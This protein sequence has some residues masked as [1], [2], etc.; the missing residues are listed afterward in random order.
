[1]NYENLAKTLLELVGGE[2]NIIS[3]THCATRLRFVLKDNKRPDE[4]KIKQQKGVVSTVRGGG[5]FQVVIGSDVGR[6]Y[7]ELLKLG[8]FNGS[9]TPA[10][11][12]RS[13]ATN[14]LDFIAGSFT[15]ILPA[16]TGA[17]MIKAVLALLMA[18]NLISDQSVTYKVLEIMSDGAFYFLPIFLAYTSAAK[19]KANPFLAMGIAGALL[20]PNFAGLFGEGVLN[21]YFLGFLPIR[22][23]SYG[24]SVIPILLS[25]FFMSYVERFADRISPKSVKFFLKPLIVVLVVT[26]IT[27]SVFGPIGSIIGDYLVQGV[28]A[29][30]NKVGFIAVALMGAFS[31][32]MV[33]FGMHYAFFPVMFTS[34][35]NFGYEALMIPGMLAA[36]VA[37][38][39]AALGVALKSKDKEIKE[40][41]RSTGITAVMGI[42][43]P[44]MY[45]VNLKY[46]KPFVAVMIAGGIS[47]FF[48]GLTG[49]K[50]YTIASPG[51]AALPIF[52]GE[53]TGF[54]FACITVVLALVISFVISYLTYKDPEVPAAAVKETVS[55]DSVDTESSEVI[56]SPLK[57]E[58]LPL[59]QVNDPAFAEGILGEGLAV[60]PTEGKLYA[61]VSGTVNV[62]FRTKH[63]VGLKSEYGA[64]IL[65]HIGLDTVKL[66]GEHFVSHVN[67][68]DVVKVGDLLVTFDI[69]AIKKSGY[70][71]ITPVL[72]TN[73]NSYS[74]IILTDKK[75]VVSNQNLIELR[76]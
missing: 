75:E 42:T 36:N 20:H 74:E 51:L 29:L 22:N 41:A 12:K 7:S 68:G 21:V 62:M 30:N 39:G 18:F 25:V 1:M 71:I 53:G 50:A 13:I 6:V 11:E 16:I 56:M 33:M 49:V 72:V 15:P 59:S 58:V 66:E 4:E 46:K 8:S 45:G 31:P 10:D 73:M 44:A 40:I 70:D 24:T 17:G 52:I 28:E 63:A 14:I 57:G 19:L 38:G 69:E 5:Q 60:I 48:A 55:I 2:E 37:Q 61:P 65:I 26:P 9:D 35:A 32:L 23:V 54:I 76:V 67:Q 34:L 3:A 27:F 47:G 64:E 43:E